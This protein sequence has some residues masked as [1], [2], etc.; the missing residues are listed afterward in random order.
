MLLRVVLIAS[1]RI[2]TRH[3]II[4]RMIRTRR[5]TSFRDRRVA[6]NASWQTV[7]ANGPNSLTSGR[8]W[9]LGYT[10]S[11]DFTIVS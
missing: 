8:A 1:S 9:R 5:S 10:P 11:V 2:E 4:C 3:R 7:S 6:T